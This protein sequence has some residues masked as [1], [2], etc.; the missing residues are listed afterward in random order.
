MA[1]SSADDDA[2]SFTVSTVW[3][4]ER[5]SC[6]H[7]D[8]LRAYQTASLPEGA[9]AFL[10]FHLEESQC[11]YCSAVL[12]DF[13]VADERVTQPKMEDLRERLLRSTAVALRKAAGRG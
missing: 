8:V 3:R 7:P 1:A 9:M 4:E 10:R 6:P 13:R 12:Q 2:L 5:V 11:P